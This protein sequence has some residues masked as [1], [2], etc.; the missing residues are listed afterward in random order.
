MS[1]RAPLGINQEASRRRWLWQPS[2]AI[3]RVAHGRAFRTPTQSDYGVEIAQNLRASVR[4]SGLGAGRGRAC[5]RREVAD[6][7]IGE[8]TLETIFR[9]ALTKRDL[10][11][12]EILDVDMIC[13]SPKQGKF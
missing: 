7:K 5:S 10:S 13:G 8:L 4:D 9:R 2:R 3:G 11:A 12:K 1:R 6:A